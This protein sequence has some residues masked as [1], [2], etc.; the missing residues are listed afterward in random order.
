MVSPMA[1][2]V[3]VAPFLTQCRLTL[4]MAATALIFIAEPLPAPALRVWFQGGLG[5]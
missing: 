2:A 5:R 4:S 1:R 3:A